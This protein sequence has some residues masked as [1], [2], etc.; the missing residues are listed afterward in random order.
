MIRIDNLKK[1]YGN[2]VVFA[3]VNACFEEG[4]IHGLLGLNGA[5]KSTLLR[6]LAGVY[7]P[8]EGTIALDGQSLQE[9]PSLKEKIFF[10]SDDPYY[11][12]TATVKD[13]AKFYASF[14]PSFSKEELRK[15]LAL[16]QV[17]AGGALSAFSKGMRRK[18][19]IAMAFASGCE[20][21]LLDE[22]FDGLDPTARI[23]FRKMLA[24]FISAKK[25]NTV[26]IASHSLRELEDIADSFS[27]IKDGE[28]QS[29]LY[30]EGES[31]LF[32]VQLAF[33]EPVDPKQFA[34]LQLRKS[35]ADGR[36]LTLYVS[37]KEDDIEKYLRQFAPLLIQIQPAS[38]EETFVEET[39]ES[40]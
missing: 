9:H 1:S 24:D 15:N 38:L 29:G 4:K 5:G 18:V 36:F 19:Y 2:S 14:Y 7:R 3:H 21:L 27:L 8:E 34:G 31:K 25:A 33:K 39:E 12:A 35:F 30:Q 23:V 11:S 28:I 32:K 37:G 16:L 17:T 22:V 10:L 26:L 20:V 13:V 6:L 40:L